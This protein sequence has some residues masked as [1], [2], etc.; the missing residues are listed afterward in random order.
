MDTASI[1]NQCLLAIGEDAGTLAAPLSMSRADILTIINQ[2]YQGPI[3]RRLRL[4]KSYSYDASDAA[5]TIT[6]G[7][8]TLPTDFLAPSRVY[9]GDAPDDR[10]LTQITDIGYKV[11]DDDT[12]SQY[13]LPNMSEI[14]IFGTTP[15]NEIK[16]YH[17]FEFVAL[18]DSASSSPSYLKKEFHQK[19]FV[20]AT[21]G[22][23]ATRQSDYGDEID[24]EIFLKDI[25]D[26]IEDA[27]TSGMRDEDGPNGSPY[28]SKAVW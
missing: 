7:V 4:L 14:W 5:H 19:P 21:Q 12:T 22:V 28:R 8:G 24:M 17:Y 2:V 23:Y 1:I 15:T 11:A 6:A 16:M 27:H 3:A 26:E 25:L 9:D 18:T 13:M 10:P 20:K